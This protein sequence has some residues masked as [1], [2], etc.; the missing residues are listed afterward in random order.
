MGHKK[1]GA[2]SQ[3]CVTLSLGRL[4]TV[5]AEMLC[6]RK[7]Q[8]AAQFPAKI[9]AEVLLIA[10]QQMCSPGMDRG[11]QYRRVFFREPYT[12]RHRRSASDGPDSFQEFCESLALVLFGQVDSRFCGGIGRSH[13]LYLRERPQAGNAGIWPIGGGKEH[14]G[15]EEQPVPGHARVG[16]RGLWCGTRLGS[17]PSF[18][19]S[20]IAAL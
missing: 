11:L 20:A 7:D 13:Q 19:T 15:I 5:E 14:V 1:G 16:L 3:A 18:F 12:P 9:T 17:I 6:R 10:G 4:S 2:T 8:H